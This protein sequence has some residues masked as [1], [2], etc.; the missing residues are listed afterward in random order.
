MRSECHL[1]ELA[2]EEESIS[3]GASAP[4]GNVASK[5]TSLPLTLGLDGAAYQ[6]RITVAP[7][8]IVPPVPL[9]RGESKLSR[10]SALATLEGRFWEV[11][12]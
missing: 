4:E 6:L 10:L 3:T 9:D 2:T 1:L 11:L 12:A 8:G 5:N 7:Q